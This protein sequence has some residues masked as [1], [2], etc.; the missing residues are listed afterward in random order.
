MIS[1][2][3]KEYARTARIIFFFAGTLHLL[4]ILMNWDIVFGPWSIPPLMS[5]IFVIIAYG[6]A[7]AAKRI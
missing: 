7:L 4:R 3:K 1:M 6:M 2:D 5:M